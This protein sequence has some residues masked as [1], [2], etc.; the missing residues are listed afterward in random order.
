MIDKTEYSKVGYL[1]V[2]NDGY[3]QTCRCNNKEE[4]DKIITFAISKKYYVYYG[5]L[6]ENTIKLP[7]YLDE[8]SLKT[9][10]KT[11]YHISEKASQKIDEEL[12]AESLICPKCSK[13]CSSKSGYTL[14]IKNC[15]KT[16]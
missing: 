15:N 7:Y 1:V 3:K 9:A 10:S 6:E 2:G 8:N 11:E 13:A 12:N 14:H 5:E 4:Y 16:E